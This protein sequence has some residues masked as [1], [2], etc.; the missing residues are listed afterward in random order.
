MRRILVVDDEMRF[1]GGINNATPPSRPAVLVMADS[2]S[3]GARHV[4]LLCGIPLAEYL[5]PLLESWG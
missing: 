3:D 4:R 2:W 5:M 1:C